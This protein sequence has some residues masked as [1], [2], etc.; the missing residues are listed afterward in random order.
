MHDRD[1][2]ACVTTGNTVFPSPKARKKKLMTTLGDAFVAIFTRFRLTYLLMQLGSI[3]RTN[4][5]LP[6]HLYRGE[7]RRAQ[8]FACPRVAFMKIQL[9]VNYRREI[10]NIVARISQRLFYVRTEIY[11]PDPTRSFVL[12]AATARSFASYSLSRLLAW[13]FSFWPSARSVYCSLLRK[14]QWL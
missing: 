8:Y 2:G 4:G 3:K 14:W 6:E 7:L 5:S 9:S 13:E 11:R 12:N 10:T 1:S